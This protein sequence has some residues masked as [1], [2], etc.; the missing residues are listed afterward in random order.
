MTNE[1]VIK[2]M[3]THELAV[4]ILNAEHEC[5][6]RHIC[7]IGNCC[8]TITLKDEDVCISHMCEWLESEVKCE[9]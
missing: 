2:I 1:D 4:F 5:Y 6:C 8:E 9:S 7:E 3:N